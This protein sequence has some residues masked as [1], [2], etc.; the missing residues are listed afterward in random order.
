MAKT[1]VINGVSYPDSPSINVMTS[2]GTE[3]LYH[4][5]SG[6]TATAADVL[7]GKRAYG[8][9]GEITGSMPDNGST[10]GTISTYDLLN[11]DSLVITEGAVAKLEE[12]YA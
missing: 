6:A 5:T 9:S 2:G 4:D 1:I 8:P 11:A 10:G 3:A 7:A 12:V